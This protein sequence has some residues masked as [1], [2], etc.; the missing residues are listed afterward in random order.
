MK[1]SAHACDSNKKAGV[2]ISVVV[3]VYN[4]DEVLP[5][6]HKRTSAVLDSMSI[7]AEVI[8]VN[9]GSDDNTLPVLMDLRERDSRVAI[10]DL[11]RNFGK[12]IALSAGLD[13]AKGSAVIVIDADLQDPPELI[14]TLVKDWQDGFD[15]VYAKRSTR[16]GETFLKKVTAHAFYRLISRVSRVEMPEDVGD[17]RLLSRQTV[18]SLKQLREQHRSMK[19]LFAWIGYSQKAVLYQRE[20]RFAGQSKWS[21][22]SLWNFAIEGITSYTIAPLK[23][24]TYVGIAVALL[25]FVY[26]GVIVYRTLMYGNPV[27]G[28]PSLIVLILFLGGVQLIT[29]GMIGEYLGR[30]FDETKRR[31]LYFVRDYHPAEAKLPT[32]AESN[33][34]GAPGSPA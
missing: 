8:Y 2:L 5:A 10:V 11:S 3:P 28:Y 24:A 27:A 19:G 17:F 33:T 21:Y 26:A 31:P 23:V 1:D 22:W 12:E 15:V 6:F 29:L 13:Y 30:V 16:E 25:A 7:A 9:D 20:P 32:L 18:E 14:P 4:E 34:N